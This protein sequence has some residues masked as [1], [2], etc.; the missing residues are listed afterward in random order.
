MIV[1]SGVYQGPRL[2]PIS[3]VSCLNRDRPLRAR[4]R[5]GALLGLR[6][7]RMIEDVRAQVLQGPPERGHYTGDAYASLVA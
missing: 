6:P 3:A 5:G 7:D 1:C 4:S 2:R